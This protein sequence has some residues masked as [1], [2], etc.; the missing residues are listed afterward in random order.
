[1]I[2]FIHDKTSRTIKIGCAW[3]PSRRLSTLQISTSNKL[4]L[5]GSIPGM[6]K[7]EK[8]VHSLVY[9]HCGNLPGERP[10]C[11]SGEWFDDRILP[12]VTELMASP[13]T[14][15]EPAKKKPPRTRP[16]DSELRECSIVLVCDSGET[17]RESFTLKA[18]SP[19]LAL[20]ALADIAN[21]RLAFLA[22]TVRI[23][24]LVVPGCRTKEVSLR[25]AFVT[26]CNH[27][28]GLSVIINSETDN[29]QL[30]LDGIKQYST[31]WLH[32]TPPEFYQAVSRWFI[33]PTAQCELLLSQF[34]QALNRNGCVIVAQTILPVRGVYPHGIG[35]LPRGELRSKVNQKAASKRRQQALE[36]RP[37]DGVV[38]FIQDKATGAI[39]IGFCLKK[40][41][42]RL[43][44]LQ[45]G[46]ANPLHLLGHVRGS[47]AHEKGLHLRFSPCRIQGE[48]FS[49]NI[50]GKVRRILECSSL[51]EWLSRQDSES[52]PAAPVDQEKP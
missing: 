8:Q 35:P 44:A 34:A 26:R 45:T 25:G 14:F 28:H 2:Y 40:P 51:E 12:F 52:A 3:N 21:A 31:R 16:V 27:R 23:T 38:Y 46:N 48:W 11:V 47:E 9:R 10:L 1:M 18:A 36:A 17:F 4:V 42:K 32:G 49:T 22:Q 29:G 20:A 13:H 50:L 30:M 37:K 15:L 19:E 5:L 41:E 39:K 43:A 6:K 33:Q 7:V 24:R